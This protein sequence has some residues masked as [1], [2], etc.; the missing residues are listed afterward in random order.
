MKL[1]ID[2]AAMTATGRRQRNEDSY[3]ANPER[4]LFV[5]ADG[6]GGHEGGQVASQ[7]ATRTISTFFDQ[8]SHTNGDLDP[9]RTEKDLSFME[10]M[11]CLSV[12]LAHRAVKAKRRGRLAQMGST[13]VVAALDEDVLTVGHIGDSRV[14][15]L[16]DGYLMRLTRDHSFL[17]ELVDAGYTLDSNTLNRYQGLI[18]RALGFPSGEG[19]PALCRETLLPGDTLL[20]STDGLHDVL[21]D[22]EI[23]QHLTNPDADEACEELVRE[24]Y[25]R[26]S[27]DNIT[28][29]VVR[30]KA[31]D[32]VN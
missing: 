31:P 27:H 20:L 19:R 23:A 2:I 28:A 10:N 30:A 32:D 4:G 5:I 8:H 14:Y 18:T 26:G 3:R 16:R 29:L 15:L 9:W 13:V 7:I 11:V 21:R 1:D 6:M 25:E 12:R 17:N 24:A 22:E